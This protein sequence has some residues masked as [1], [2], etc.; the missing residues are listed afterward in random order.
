MSGPPHP[1]ASQDK[2]GTAINDNFTFW[3]MYTANPVLTISRDN[4]MFDPLNTTISSNSLPDNIDVPVLD[5]SHALMKNITLTITNVQYD[6]FGV[7]S[8]SVQNR[9]GPLLVSV[10]LVP[11]GKIHLGIT[12]LLQ[13]SITNR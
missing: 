7:Y 2:Y 8:L 3:L 13:L 4:W 5:S 10:E 9:Y 11:E 12:L 6:N 1:A